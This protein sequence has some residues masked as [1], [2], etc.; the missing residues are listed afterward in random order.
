MPV[1]L[2]P[3]ISGYGWDWNG[4]DQPVYEAA[5]YVRGPRNGRWHRPRYGIARPDRTTLSFWCGAGYI[6]LDVALMADSVPEADPVCGTCEGRALGAGQDDTPAG[7]PRLAFEP[8]WLVPPATCPGSGPKAGL[9]EDLNGRVGRCLACQELTPLRAAHG[10]NYDGYGPT[11]HRP[12][13]GL[14]PPCPF[15]AWNRI[16]LR[17]DGSVGCRCGWTESTA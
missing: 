6:R 5:R 2:L 10:W 7:M 1:A 8:R 17:A 3:P 11:N 14:V 16:G 4:V 9:F 13:P 12:G 15:H